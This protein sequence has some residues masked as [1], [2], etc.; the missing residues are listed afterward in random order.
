[1]KKSVDR[2]VEASN[3]PLSVVIVGVGNADFADMVGHYS[4]L[5]PHHYQNSF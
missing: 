1:M 5:T 4:S 3:H 2:I